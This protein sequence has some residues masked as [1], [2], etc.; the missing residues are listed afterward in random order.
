ML[1]GASLVLFG[2]VLLVM[3]HDLREEPAWPGERAAAPRTRVM[4]FWWTGV[5]MVA[6]GLVL[7]VASF[8]V[9]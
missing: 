7:A 3:T 6:I 9:L 2:V 5:A 4:G 1:I 8:L